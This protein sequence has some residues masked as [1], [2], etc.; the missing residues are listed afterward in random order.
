M[1]TDHDS[2][3]NAGRQAWETNILDMDHVIVVVL[4]GAFC[5]VINN[6]C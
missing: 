1:E 4:F 2:G 3:M 5:D 6:A